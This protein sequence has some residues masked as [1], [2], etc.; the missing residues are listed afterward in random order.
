[1]IWF[2]MLEKYY[3]NETCISETIIQE[4]PKEHASRPTIFKFLDSA[5]KKGYIIKNVD[6]N[7]KRRQILSP[8][9]QMIMEF[10]DW[11]TGFKGF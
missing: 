4:L 10:E 5:I 2:W 7:D 11:A 9:V 8:S 1:M 3:K 6:I